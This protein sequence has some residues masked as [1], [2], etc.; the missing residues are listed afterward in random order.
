MKTD[1]RVRYTQD[2][3]Q[4]AFLELLREK[5]VSKITV[6]EVCN[7]AEINRGTFYKHYQDCYD[8]ME[9]IEESAL[10][11]FDAMLDAEPNGGAQEMLVS[12]LQA[13]KNNR[14]MFE[15]MAFLQ[16]GN[17]FVQKLAERYFGR[18]ELWQRDSAAARWKKEPQK[19]ISGAFL[20]GGS[21][22]IIEYWL[23]SGMKEKPERIAE[24]ILALAEIV[25]SGME[26]G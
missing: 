23:Q 5:P 24:E 12:I 18:M 19:T 26:K 25:Q 11:K 4:K 8:L 9:K 21:S 7:T 1:L 6:K 20:A 3:I 10:E 15:S 22:G 16:E 14:R 13:L 17:R 2:V